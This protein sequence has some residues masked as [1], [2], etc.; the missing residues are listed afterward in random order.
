MSSK[1]L[2]TELL[3]ARDQI[4]Q[5][6][7][8][9]V[10]LLAARFELTRQVGVLKAKKKFNALDGAREAQKLQDLNLLSKDKGLNPEFITELFRR[11]MDEVVENHNKLRQE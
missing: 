6:D 11:I 5:I 3:E 9:L 1:E 2:P 4:D 10:E 8:D 7:Q